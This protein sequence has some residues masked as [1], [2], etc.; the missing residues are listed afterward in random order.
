[1]QRTHSKLLIYWAR[2]WKWQ[3]ICDFI[4]SGADI[5]RMYC[6]KYTYKIY[7]YVSYLTNAI[8]SFKMLSI[9]CGMEV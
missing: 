6:K 9:R 5:G 7:S 8:N 1:M 2:Y 4:E 3:I